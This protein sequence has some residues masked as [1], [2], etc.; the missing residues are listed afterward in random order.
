MTVVTT[1]SH[2]ATHQKP[3]LLVFTTTNTPPPT[4]TTTTTVPLF[5]IA[6]VV[7]L[8]LYYRYTMVQ[9]MPIMDCD[10]IYNYWEP[11]HFVWFQ[12]GFQTWE[13]HTW[14]QLR[15]YA[16]LYHPLTLLVQW[17]YRSSSSSSFPFTTTMTMTDH[18]DH[19]PVD[20][21]VL[22]LMLRQTVAI[23]TA[24][25]ELFFL[26]AVWWRYHQNPGDA[27]SSN[28]RRR[29]VDVTNDNNNDNHTTDQASWVP[30]GTAVVLLTGT[31]MNHAASALLPSATYMSIW[32]LAAACFL[33]QHYTGF[34]AVAITGTLATGWP[35]GCI[36]V[37]PMALH[38]CYQEVW[39]DRRPWTFLITIVII[40]VLV[41]AV[42]T[43]IDMIHY[44]SITFPTLNIFVYNAGQSND[45]LYGVEPLSYYIKNLLLN[46]NIASIL[47]CLAIPVYLLLTTSTTSTTK[48][49]ELVQPRHFS[50]PRY[51][52]KVTTI[53]LSLPIW[54][55]ITLPRPHKEERFMYP[56]YP[57][58]M[59]GAVI[60]MDVLWSHVLRLVMP[61]FHR[62][63]RVPPAMSS[64]SSS[65]PNPS[66]DHWKRWYHWKIVGCIVTCLPIVLLSWS[67]TY[68]LYKYYHAPID[69][70]QHLSTVLSQSTAAANEEHLVCT[71]GEWYR[72]MS[73]FYLPEGG[74]VQIP[75][76]FVPSSFRG[77][78][79]Q[80]FSSH[81][82]R[83]ESLEH[84]Q[85]FNDRNAEETDRYVKDLRQCQYL[86]DVSDSNDCR[87]QWDA[88]TNVIPVYAVPFL[89]ADRT[90]TWYHRIWYIPYLH[91][92]ARDQ[93]R[94]TYKN[95]T[96]YRLETTAYNDKL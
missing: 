10:E 8:Y 76:G 70:Y 53:L 52:A 66:R 43:W 4:T 84:L 89:D 22:F 91:E 26:Y 88:A 11:L 56:I 16:Y 42:V 68:A 85:P 71:C 48:E 61:P 28:R 46:C 94:V 40:T 96:L 93:G 81:G 37:I 41:Q 32:C 47:G 59:F 49:S 31:G 54:F 73:S 5:T 14:Y 63:P 65:P 95:Y 6:V 25:C 90:T 36:C 34:I 57:V 62:P 15:T 45:T 78:L 67:R 51:D 64:S 23:A 86:I 19:H 24:C 18:H 1:T 79:P 72:Y 33:R 12:R 83:P 77:Q 82:S 35:F 58:L 9:Y 87:S 80:P 74:A 60:T 75:I 3:P 69:V 20:K 39:V 7:P 29:S 50:T 2:D 13:Y 44:G 38:I 55:L 27:S 21:A 30:Y 92:R 17:W